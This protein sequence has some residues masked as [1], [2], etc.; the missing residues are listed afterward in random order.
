MASSTGSF[1]TAEWRAL[2]NK[3][4]RCPRCLRRWED[5]LPLP[6]RKTVVTRDHIV[7]ISRGGS[8]S[9]ENIQPLCYA[10]NSKKGQ[11]E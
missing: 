11:R 9:I 1:T 2:L 6:G 4:E 10:C 3:Y 5:I 8:N 7:P